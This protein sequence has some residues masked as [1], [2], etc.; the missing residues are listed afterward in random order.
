MTQ[1][2]IICI[3]QARRGSSR[4]PDKILMPLGG[5]PVLA[6]VIRRAKAINLVS[7]VVVAVP[8]EDASAP[9]IN[10]AISE[11]V[12]AYKGS[13]NDVLDRYYQAAI[14]NANTTGQ[15][16]D[17]VIR[18]TSDCPLLSSTVCDDLVH[19][20]LNAQAQYGGNS[21]FPH[22]LD[23]E[24]FSLDLLREAHQQATNLHDR[25]HVTLWIKRREDIKTFFLHADGHFHAANRWVVDY[26]QDYSFLRALY[27]QMG[28]EILT[29]S[30]QNIVAFVD[31]HPDLRIINKEQTGL[32]AEKT[33]KII[34]KASK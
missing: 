34:D 20:Y 33:N 9:L 7:H 2:K 31:D 12:S 26:P 27:D 30:W 8:D 18:I 14:E 29:A 3:I 24:I 5:I 19:G 28:S 23:C 6:H 4:L 25:E 22:G 11:G 21:Q 1:P 32:W 10:L 15:P 16:A 17:H 13:E